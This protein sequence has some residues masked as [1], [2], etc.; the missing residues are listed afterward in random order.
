MKKS[1][2]ELSQADINRI[3]QQSKQHFKVNEAY[4]TRLR[5]ELEARD[6]GKSFAEWMALSENQKVKLWEDVE[7]KRLA[8]KNYGQ[9]VEE[10]RQQKRG[11]I[12]RNEIPAEW[13]G[14]PMW[15][16]DEYAKERPLE[17]AIEYVRLLS[18]LEITRGAAQE[19]IIAEIAQRVE[20]GWVVDMTAEEAKTLLLAEIDRAGLTEV[21]GAAESIRR[22]SGQ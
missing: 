5:E 14:F 12:E 20:R 17:I 15:L 4:C 7:D 2:Q 22:G 1:N 11:R 8:E 16:R 13:R 6:A 9:T 21:F 10:Y 18:S 19:E 3:I